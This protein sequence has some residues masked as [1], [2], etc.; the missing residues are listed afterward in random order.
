MEF[1]SP[2]GAEHVDDLLQL[3]AQA[4]WTKERTRDQ[5]IGLLDRGDLT[6]GMISDGRLV[7]FVRAFTDWRFKA[8]VMDL[9]VD[10][11][12]RHTGVSRQLLGSLLADP[13]VARIQDIELYCR[14]EL[15]PY[16]ETLGFVEPPGTHFMRR[17]R[18]DSGS[19]R[20]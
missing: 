5:I 19:G 8:M 12:I 11:P 18:P 13:R 9:I 3:F 10:E 16:Y 6:A 17:S 20:P 14:E 2:V 1:I 4:W 15:M 7:A